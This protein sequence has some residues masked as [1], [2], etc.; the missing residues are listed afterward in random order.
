MGENLHKITEEYFDLNKVAKH[1]LELYE[2]SLGLVHGRD[3]D[4]E[5]TYNAEWKY[6]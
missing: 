6:E 1:R 2:Q 4:K 5:I 3:H